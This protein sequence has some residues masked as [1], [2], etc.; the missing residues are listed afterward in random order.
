MS[1]IPEINDTVY[2]SGIFTTP[3]DEQ[4]FEP[5]P[6]C[7]NDGGI[8]IFDQVEFG[9][10]HNCIAVKCMDGLVSILDRDSGL[11]REIGKP[12]LRKVQ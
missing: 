9:Q 12:V 4:D 3:Q 11:W 5:L 7:L 10:I 6:L 1:E 2:E 8:A